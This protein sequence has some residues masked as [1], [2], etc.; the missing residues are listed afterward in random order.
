MEAHKRKQAD[1]DVDSRRQKLKK[2]RADK[3]DETAVTEHEIE[4]FFAILR[5]IHVAVTYFRN[6]NGG[7]TKYMDGGLRAV[8]ESNEEEDGVKGKKEDVGW[9]LNADPEPECDLT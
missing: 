4:E 6:A 9:D 7:G 1:D 8:L 2:A 3:R 5:R